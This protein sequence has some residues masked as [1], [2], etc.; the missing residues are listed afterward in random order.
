MNRQSNNLSIRPKIIQDICYALD[1]IYGCLVVATV[2]IVTIYFLLL[3]KHLKVEHFRYLW[4]VRV[5]LIYGYS[6][7]IL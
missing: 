7:K 4:S 1:G 5:P 6:Y 2:Y 3:H